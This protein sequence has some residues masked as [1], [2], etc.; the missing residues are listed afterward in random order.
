MLSMNCT[1]AEFLLR[2]WLRRHSWLVFERLLLW[3]GVSESCSGS[4]WAEFTGTRP[5]INYGCMKNWKKFSQW[6][7]NLRCLLLMTLWRVLFKIWV[8]KVQLICSIVRSSDPSRT[9][10][11]L[12]SVVIASSGQF[13]CPRAMA[14]SNLSMRLNTASRCSVTLVICSNLY[15]DIANR[16]YLGPIS[17]LRFVLSFDTWM[18]YSL[19]RN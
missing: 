11:T 9:P 8:W 1:F 3:I 18:E 17:H 10:R 14:G 7:H 4:A 13:Q 5:G 19:V 6:G 16:F 15:Y 12:A 2:P